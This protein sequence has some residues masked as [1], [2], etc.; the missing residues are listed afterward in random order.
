MYTNEIR[1]LRSYRATLIPK[2]LD[3]SEV[4][5]HAADGKLPTIQLKAASADRAQAAAHHTTGLAVLCV[6][7]VGGGE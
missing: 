3:R 2:D 4:Y 6:D 7:R 1:Q 5:G